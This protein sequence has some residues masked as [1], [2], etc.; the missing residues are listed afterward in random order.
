MRRNLDDTTQKTINQVYQLLLVVVVLVPHSHPQLNLCKVELW[1]HDGRANEP[2]DH[3]VVVA[4]KM[5]AGRL[6]SADSGGSCDSVG[7]ATAH[8]RSTSGRRVG[9]ARAVAAI[10][11]FCELADRATIGG[12]TARGGKVSVARV[13]TVVVVVQEIVDRTAIRG[14]TRSCR[15]VA[16]ARVVA[17]VGVVYELVDRSARRGRTASGREMCVV[18]VVA[19]ATVCELV[20]VR[21][22]RIGSALG[23]RMCI[24]RRACCTRNAGSGMGGRC[25]EDRSPRR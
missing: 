14:R 17:V 23:K 12:R 1:R 2:E 24:R 3:G 10:V 8:E 19:I 15:D 9:R 20:N 18:P 21:V 6:G 13:V 25:V 22:G 7:P 16:V 5:A 11:V 4:P